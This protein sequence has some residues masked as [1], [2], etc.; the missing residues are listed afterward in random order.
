VGHN[1]GQRKFGDQP[2]R[3]GHGWAKISRNFRSGINDVCR[4][5]NLHVEGFGRRGPIMTSR[6]AT[7]SISAI[8][9]CVCPGI[10]K[11][12]GISSETR[13]GSWRFGQ[14]Q[15]RPPLQI[16]TIHGPPDY[17]GEQKTSMFH[18]RSNLRVIGSKFLMCI[19]RLP[20]PFR[21]LQPADPRRDS[22]AQM[23]GDGREKNHAVPWFGEGITAHCRPVY[24]IRGW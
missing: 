7:P 24:Q 22:P 6:S 4:N 19:G 8:A 5:G 20:T 9:V 18:C 11:I 3:T 21:I 13:M 14:M 23:H 10:N 12:M 2:I 1:K 17:G 16:L 15:R